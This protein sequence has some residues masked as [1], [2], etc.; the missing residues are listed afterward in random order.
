MKLAVLFHRLGPYHHARL[1]AVG[2]QCAL[3]AIELSAVDKTYAWAEIAGAENFR[4][5]TLFRDADADDKSPSEIRHEIWRA[6]DNCNPQL[7]AIPGWGGVAA[8]LALEWC[9][10]Q[11]VP[12]LV[13]SAST[14]MDER[15]VWWREWL[16]SQVVRQFDAGLG[17]GTPHVDYFVKLGLPRNRTFVGYDVVDN[18][19][20]SQGAD[21]ARSQGDKLLASKSL[22][23]KFFL[24]SSRFVGKKNLTRLIDAYATYQKS[25][26][27]G[28]WH[29]VIIGDGPLRTEVE[30]QISRLELQSWIHL[31]GF[32]QYDEL[33]E[34]YGLAGAYVQASTTEQWGLVVNEAMASGLPVL[35]SN[36]CGCAPDLVQPGINGYTFDPYNVEELAG[37]MRKLA[38]GEC[39]LTG[40]GQ[41][42]RKIIADWSP[43]TFAKNLLNAAN[44]ALAT[45]K[46]RFP[47]FD[48]I[49]LKALTCR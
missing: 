22:P 5:I 34:Y 32:K 35:V 39:E 7:V 6:L 11:N 36:R 38:G 16:K 19:Y 1:R 40:M 43:E 27:P 28:A 3:T 20:F 9:R 2:E 14:E 21:A 30:K 26:E 44:A 45:P 31:P 15:R 48:R 41:A 18:D 33:P 13:M 23:E 12:T 8:F 37:L 25:V 29:L 24:N 47:W 17:G 49:L 46:R 42:S 4:R 10:Q